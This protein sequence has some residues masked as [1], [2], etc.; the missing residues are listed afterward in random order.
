MIL[1]LFI[2]FLIALFS[3]TICNAQELPRKGWFG[4]QMETVNEQ[5]FKTLKLKEAQ[6]VRVIQSVGGT[7]KLLELKPDDAVLS[8]NNQTISDVAAL[9]QFIN[10]AK[11]GL[12]IEVKLI[13]KGKLITLKGTIVGRPRETDANADVIYDSAPYKEGKLSV[14][15]NK[16][17]KE[18]KLPAV[19]FIP[20]YTCSSVDGL[21]ESH[22]YGRV[23][24][25]FSDAGYVVLRIEKSGLG[26][27]ENTPSCD[28]SHLYD[29]VDIFEQGLLKL[30]SLSY[31]DKE[32]ILIFGHSMGGVVGPAI[33]AKH[34]VKGIMV[35]GTTAKSWFEYILE[36]N[37]LQTMLANPDPLQFEELC[38]VQGE[39]AYEYYIQKKDLQDIARDSIKSAILKTDWQYDGNQMIFNRNNEYWRQIQDYPLLENWKNTKAK[40][41]VVFGGTDFQAFSKADHE[42]I[43]YTVNFYH[44]GNASLIVF[45]ETDHYFAKTGTMQKAFDTFM[46]GNYQELFDAFDFEVTRGL[47]EWA[48]RVTSN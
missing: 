18:G 6:G 24:R 1:T 41:L 31:V 22:P 15:I 8:I 36:M 7:S 48:N 3:A 26:D 27:S 35:Y 13:R 40:V 39:I 28:D 14:I 37:R 11:E 34:N 23:V 42:Q 19:L 45:P 33:S 16:P 4:A 21:S 20:G 47:I 25:K 2:A 5:N 43:V 46:S 30:Q 12:P 44:P 10:S 38:R 32:N 9:G 29:E 17:R